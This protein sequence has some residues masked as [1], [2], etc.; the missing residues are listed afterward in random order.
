M[1]TSVNSCPVVGGRFQPRD[2]HPAP[3]EAEGIQQVVSV[4]G[5][6]GIP[7]ALSAPRGGAEAGREEAAQRGQRAA[8][9]GGRQGRGDRGG[10]ACRGA[11][12]G[13]PG[14]RKEQCGG[15][16][17][18]GVIQDDVAAGHVAVEAELLQVL[19]ERALGGGGG[20]QRA[21]RSGRRPGGRAD[22][23]PS[24]EEA[25]RAPRPHTR[26]SAAPCPRA[27]AAGPERRRGRA[28]PPTGARRPAGCRRAPGHQQ[29]GVEVIERPVRMNSEGRPRP[30]T[31]GHLRNSHWEPQR[32]AAG[33]PE[34][35]QDK[36]VPRTQSRCRCAALQASGRSAGTPRPS[37][38]TRPRFRLAPASRGTPLPRTACCFHFNVRGA[39]HPRGLPL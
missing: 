2:P 27:P 38:R 4:L 7:Q 17:H 12:E 36:T 33:R 23:V 15:D 30:R 5:F 18:R 13:R 26:N 10:P 20:R 37:G 32:R 6:S 25:P 28:G 3:L 29:R 34:Q 1:T 14:P 19:D 39:A 11:A 24:P 8:G 21:A 35:R 22:P 31:V 9:L 16:T